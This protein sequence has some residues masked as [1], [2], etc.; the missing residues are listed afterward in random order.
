MHRCFP[1]YIVCVHTEQVEKS[2]ILP[3]G[4]DGFFQSWCSHWDKYVGIEALCCLYA[5]LPWFEE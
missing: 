3:V 5:G 4:L 2:Q 1:G